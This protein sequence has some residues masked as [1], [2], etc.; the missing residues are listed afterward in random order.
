LATARLRNAVCLS[1]RRYRKPESG[2]QDRRQLIG[3][4]TRVAAV[5]DGITT[6]TRYSWRHRGMSASD[7]ETAPSSNVASNTS[8]R[9]RFVDTQLSIIMTSF[10]KIIFVSTL[11]ILGKERSQ[12]SY[13]PNNKFSEKRN[14]YD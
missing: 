4:A 13:T 5:A 7:R 14:L 11:F 2:G 3:I 10:V 8:A 6:H 1:Q 12:I 9:K